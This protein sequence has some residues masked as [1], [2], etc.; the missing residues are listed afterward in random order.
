MSNVEI[1]ESLIEQGMVLPIGEQ[2]KYIN[3]T[4]T[5][6]LLRSLQTE[7]FRY[8]TDLIKSAVQL[9]GPHLPEYSPN[10]RVNFLKTVT[11]F[12]LEES[13]FEIIFTNLPL[14]KITDGNLIRCAYN[15]HGINFATTM[16]KISN[17]RNVLFIDLFESLIDI[18]ESDRHR[19]F[20]EFPDSIRLPHRTTS[21]SFDEIKRCVYKTENLSTIKGEILK[22]LDQGVTLKQLLND[23]EE[24]RYLPNFRKDFLVEILLSISSNQAENISLI[25]DFTTRLEIHSSQLDWIRLANEC[26]NLD[27]VPSST[28]KNMFVLLMHRDMHVLQN[29]FETFRISYPE[30]Y[31]KL[32]DFK[33]VV[34]EVKSV[35]LFRALAQH[36]CYTKD[37]FEFAPNLE[38]DQNLHNLVTKVFTNYLNF[39]Q[40]GEYTHSFSLLMKFVS[41]FAQ[42]GNTEMI[43]KIGSQFALRNDKM[44]L[45]SSHNEYS[46]ELCTSHCKSN[47]LDLAFNIYKGLYITSDPSFP[48]SEFL[49]CDL[50]RYSLAPDISV[51]V[52]KR[53]LSEKECFDSRTL[54]IIFRSS[55]FFDT[56]RYEAK[57]IYKELLAIGQ[58]FDERSLHALVEAARFTCDIA[59]LE[60]LV[61]EISISQKSTPSEIFGE[62]MFSYLHHNQTDNALEVLNKIASIDGY[63]KAEAKYGSLLSTYDIPII[64]EVILQ[65]ATN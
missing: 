27:D 20:M 43:K 2:A 30:N 21:L 54:T 26:T 15:Q 51:F 53:H 38:S 58:E 61:N 25:N 5:G 62:L 32:F 1:F 46:T 13:D 29:W 57:S 63:R 39:V 41:C 22:T 48:Y 10:K 44:E 36:L 45:L 49:L 18:D 17:S 19:L 9:I 64:N 37:V 16:A 50:A 6:K 3:Q 60:D 12:E 31:W 8:S 33:G 47:E 28:L 59:E 35:A 56:Y 24:D 11:T 23:I 42:I 7:E 4:F 52:F 14:F 65:W 34:G 55:G 40:E